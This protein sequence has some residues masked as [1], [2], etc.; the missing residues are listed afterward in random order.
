MKRRIDGKKKVI[1]VWAR[2][3]LE[4]RLIRVANTLDEEGYDV[5]VFAW[6]R[7]SG[8]DDIEKHD[9]FDCHYRHLSAPYDSPV[10]FLLLPIWWLSI[11]RFLMKHKPDAI[12]VCDMDCLLPSLFYGRLKRI[13]LV[14]DIFDIYGKMVQH[15]VPK[16]ISDLLVRMERAGAAASSAVIMVNEHQYDLL[17]KPAVRRLSYLVNT[18]YEEDRKKVELKIREIRKTISEDNGK[19]TLI[20]YAG[21]LQYARRFDQMLDAIKDMDDV[22]HLVAGAGA[23]ADRLVPMFERSKN[24]H[25]LGPIS[26]LEVLAWSSIAD[27]LYLLCDAGLKKYRLG[28]QTRLFVGMMCGTPMIVTDSIN[29]ARIVREEKCGLTVA[30]KDVKGLRKTIKKLASSRSLRQRLGKS[31]RRAYDKKYGWNILKQELIQLY[32]ELPYLRK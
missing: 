5:K 27:I 26:F 18:P 29:A 9:H 19:K 3:V 32:S 4:A 20:F 16:K 17:G 24:T 8:R 31:G 11:I 21:S 23:D 13:P 14:Y 22:Y 30:D 1:I 7:E 12:H 10:L 28:A 15:S 25:Y 6:D 2:T